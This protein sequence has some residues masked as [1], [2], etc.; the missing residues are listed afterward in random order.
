MHLGHKLQVH[1][2]SEKYFKESYRNIDTFY[3]QYNPSTNLE[4]FD[5]I[6]QM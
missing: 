2:L 6:R 1:L 4:N 5:I 3:D